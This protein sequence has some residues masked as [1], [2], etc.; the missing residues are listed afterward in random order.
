MEN[1]ELEREIRSRA[2]KDGVASRPAAPRGLGRSLMVPNVG[3]PPVAGA[4]HK[5]DAGD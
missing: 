2:S 4:P 3:S 5:D 1:H